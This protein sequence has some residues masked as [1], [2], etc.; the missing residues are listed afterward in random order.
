MT[1]R[2]PPHI[3]IPPLPAVI[4]TT[5]EAAELLGVS[6]LT[7]YRWIKAGKLD[8]G[9]YGGTWRIFDA[10]I[11]RMKRKRRRSRAKG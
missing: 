11:Q 8:A 3:L 1:A 2:I 6:R 5:A 10:E 7:V 9:K 4:C